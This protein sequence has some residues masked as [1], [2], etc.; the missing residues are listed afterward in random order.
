MRRILADLVLL[1]LDFFSPI[2]DEP[3]KTSAGDPE[4][5]LAGAHAGH[6]RV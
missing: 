5:R 2:N 1:F 3:E 6:P 4:P